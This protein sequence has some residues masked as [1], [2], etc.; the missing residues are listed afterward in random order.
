M[1]LGCVQ[2]KLYSFQFKE[3][4]KPTDLCVFRHLNL[5]VCVCVAGRVVAILACR[6]L[7]SL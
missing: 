4:V 1:L 7:Y 5:S 6:C 2:I 3:K